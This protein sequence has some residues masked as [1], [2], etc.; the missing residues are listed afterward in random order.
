STHN[1]YNFRI[2]HGYDLH[3]TQKGRSIMLCGL[4]I[5]CNFAI[6]SHSDGD[7]ALHALCDAILG[8]IAQG[9]IGEHFPPSDPVWKNHASSHFVQHACMLA[10]KAG[11]KIAN[12]DITIIAENPKLKKLKYA[13]RQSIADMINVPVYNV[14][15]KATTHEGVD[16]I[17]QGKAIAAHANVLMEQYQ[18]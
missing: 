11:Y 1:L 18:S 5:E 17:G 4:N 2:G 13:M 9:D 15:I 7:V 12:C 3:Q 10:K 16:S 8:A 6:K 14:S